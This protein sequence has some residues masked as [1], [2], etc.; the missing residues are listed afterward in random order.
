MG[1]DI[2]AYAKANSQGTFVN[3]ELKK[4]YAKRI[5]ELN[6]VRKG[7]F[8][9]YKTYDEI[10]AGYIG[11]RAGEISKQLAHRRELLE[12]GVSVRDVGKVLRIEAL[13]LQAKRRIGVTEFDG[14]TPEKL[15]SQGVALGDSI[16]W[17]ATKV[18][19]E[20]AKQAASYALRRN[21]ITE[22][23]RLEQIARDIKKQV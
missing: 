3:L 10:E 7:Q 14:Y 22:A 8:R 21:Q 23:L 6:E 18:L 11:N 12:E 4:L 2:V 1:A 5:D 16:G 20:F 13:G 19:A 9:N 15:Y 17:P